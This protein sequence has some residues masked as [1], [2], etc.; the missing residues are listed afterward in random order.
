MPENSAA[1][2]Y[3]RRNAEPPA[4]T[5]ASNPPIAGPATKPSPAAPLSRAMF[6]VRSAASVTSATSAC[7][8]L[9][10]AAIAPAKNR[11]TKSIASDA[12]N[13]SRT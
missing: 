6:F 13:A 3:G 7:A 12:E 1:V 9:I 5:P 4:S 10:F 11:T 8:T 2:R